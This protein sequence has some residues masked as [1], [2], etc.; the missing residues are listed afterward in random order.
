MSTSIPINRLWIYEPWDL[1]KINNFIK[2]EFDRNYPYFSTTKN[3][4][5]LSIIIIILSIIISIMT[6]DPQKIFWFCVGLVILIVVWKNSTEQIKVK[7]TFEPSTGARGINSETKL[8]SPVKK[9][10]FYC[11]LFNRG[12]I[13]PGQI[14]RLENPE[15]GLSQANEVNDIQ[16]TASE[17]PWL[18]FF[19]R[20]WQYD[21]PIDGTRIVI[22]T[23]VEPIIE[24]EV[25]P[26]L[27]IDKIP[28]EPPVADI[29]LMSNYTSNPSLNSTE[30]QDLDIVWRNQVDPQGPPGPLKCR[31]PTP[32]NPMGTLLPTDYGKKPE[33]YGTCNYGNPKTMMKMDK[34]YEDGVIQDEKGMLFHKNNAQT[35]FTPQPGDTLPVAQEQFSQFCYNI[36]TNYVNPKY[37]S[38]WANDPDKFKFLSN[39]AQATGTENGG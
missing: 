32:Q 9:D 1:F 10:S 17:I 2:T 21:F 33:F 36:P 22:L 27:N 20:P 14:V 12:K 16:N 4:N 3:I 7:E 24:K 38:I 11:Q 35:R 13:T 37:V 18:V 25:D 6:K 30:G 26:E 23:G 29:N 34:D 5:S 15:Q 39:L 19:E 31:G 8:A 28:L